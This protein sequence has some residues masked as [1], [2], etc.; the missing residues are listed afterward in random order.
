MYTLYFNQLIFPTILNALKCRTYTYLVTPCITP[1]SKL[2]VDAKAISTYHNHIKQVYG[3]PPNAISTPSNIGAI[4]LSTVCDCSDVMSKTL[5]Y[6][7]VKSNIRHQEWSSKRLC[8]TTLCRPFSSF[9]F[10][11]Q[12]NNS[13]V[14]A[15]VLV[16]LSNQML[17]PYEAVRTEL[18]VQAIN[19]TTTTTTI[20]R[21]DS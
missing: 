15:A 3:N 8:E 9:T 16:K 7:W 6:R 10:G 21:C 2:Q 13:A 19:G 14:L 5:I 11:A 17:R 4:Q 20:H 1:P 18:T 12:P